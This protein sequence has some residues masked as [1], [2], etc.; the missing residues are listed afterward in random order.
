[1]AEADPGGG[2]AG[3]FALQMLALFND[4]KGPATDVLKV[5]GHPLSPHPR[6]VCCSLLL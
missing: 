3:P 4:V 1:M 2:A 6:S 5:V